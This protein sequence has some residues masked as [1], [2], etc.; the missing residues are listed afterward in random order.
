[1][2]LCT[3]RRGALLGS[4]TLL[5]SAS[6]QALPNSAQLQA[7]GN[8]TYAEIN[9]TLRVPGTLLFAETA[10]LNGSQSGG[11]N[12]RAF[13][14]PVSTQFRVFNSLMQ[15][16]TATRA[17]TR[18]FSDQMHAAYWD[19]GY[20]SGAGGGARFYDDNAHI[21]VAL[22]EAYRLTGDSVYLD[23][24][25]ATQSFV[26]SGENGI[27]GGGIYFVQGETTSK[28]TISTL[29]GARGAAM[30]YQATGDVNYLNAAKRLVT[31][32]N[33][34][35]QLPSGLYNQGF[36]IATNSPGGIEIV[37]SAGVGISANLELYKATGQVSYLN[38]AKRVGN[39][40]SARYFSSSTG[41]LNDEGF[42]AFELAD[43]FN[44]L[45]AATD[46]E[47][48]IN[49]V[50]AALTWL[51]E[52]KR[53][54]NGHYDTFWGRNGPITTTL[55]SWNLNEQASVARAYLYTAIAVPEPGMLSAIAGVALLTRRRRN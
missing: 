44:D 29:Q 26:M 38:E 22:V 2:S 34:H 52:N 15:L 36:V 43:A 42:W 19:D 46:D 31:W 40:A 14:W 48:W 45:Y 11:F 25:K 37:N 21:V 20:R 6:A 53:D 55:G 12:N 24:A 18:L 13:V 8:E 35:V 32:A 27:A 49:R 7:W 23:R 16:D 10:S 50:G 41:A 9:R 4:L 5:L 28:D 3:I 30:L 17:R 51:H 1:M 54:P 39:A 33:S 47:T